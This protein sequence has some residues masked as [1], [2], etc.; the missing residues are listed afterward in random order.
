MFYTK[1][2][3]KNKKKQLILIIFIT[4]S[5]LLPDTVEKYCKEWQALIGN[6]A[7]ARCTLDT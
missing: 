7:L 1:V 4:K 2:V 5:Y 3:E 6:V